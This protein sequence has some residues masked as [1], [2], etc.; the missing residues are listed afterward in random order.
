MAAMRGDVVDTPVAG[1]GQAVADLVAGGGVDRGRAGPGRELVPVSRAG[2]R[3]ICRISR[4]VARRCSVAALRI[5][6]PSR[7]VPMY[8]SMHFAARHDPSV[9]T[10]DRR[11]AVVRPTGPRSV[12]MPGS[13]AVILA[14]ERCYLRT[15][16]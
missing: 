9:R 5:R 14:S 10:V 16:T 15:N 12:M 3:P 8:C 1:P 11:A 4:W 2:L 7:G 13:D 6:A